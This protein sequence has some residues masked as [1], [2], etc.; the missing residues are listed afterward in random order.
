MASVYKA[1]VPCH[2]LEKDT[3]WCNTQNDAQWC[4]TQNDAQW[5]NTQNK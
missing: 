3:Q 2:S 1:A 5:C 4:N